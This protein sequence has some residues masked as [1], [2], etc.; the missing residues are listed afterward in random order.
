M[1]IAGIDPG[2]GGGLAIIKE[3]KVNLY[4]TPTA[5]VRSGHRIKRDYLPQMMAHLLILEKPGFVF[6]EQVNSHPG[7]GVSSVF[8]FGK[9]YGIWIGII[10]ALQIPMTLVTPQAWRKKLMQGK[11]D[12]NASRLR[13]M[14]LYPEISDQLKRKSDDGRAEALLIAHWGLIEFT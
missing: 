8:S 1:I 7:E 13:A 12:K 5:K 3:E 10:A 11:P 4:D 6:L 9:G 2:L 14:E